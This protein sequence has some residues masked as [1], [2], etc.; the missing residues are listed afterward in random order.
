M[1]NKPLAASFIRIHTHASE[2]AI[3]E[4]VSNCIAKWRTFYHARESGGLSQKPDNWANIVILSLRICH[5][6]SVCTMAIMLLVQHHFVFPFVFTKGF[7][8]FQ[9]FSFLPLPLS[10][11]TYS[12]GPFCCL[13]YGMVVIFSFSQAS[14]TKVPFDSCVTWGSSFELTLLFSDYGPL[15]RRNGACT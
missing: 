14:H 2:C 7:L 3:C 4:R 15:S 8:A 9:P 13:R 5:V 1:V 12:W 10:F 6:V 11:F